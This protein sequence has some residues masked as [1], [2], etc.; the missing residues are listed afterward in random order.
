MNK[1]EM[2]FSKFLSD[3]DAENGN[4]LTGPAEAGRGEETAVNADEMKEEEV[5]PELVFLHIVIPDPDIPD[6]EYARRKRH[7]NRKNRRGVK[8]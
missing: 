4:G 2:D 6:D 3:A 1:N 5:L 8:A 7:R